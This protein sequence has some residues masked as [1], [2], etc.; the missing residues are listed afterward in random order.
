MV[1]HPSIDLIWIK[2]PLRS[3]AHRY[4]EAIDSTSAFIG[5]SLSTLNGS[6]RSGTRPECAGN[7]ASPLT[8]TSSRR[9]RSSGGA[10]NKVTRFS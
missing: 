1:D 9:T 4:G 3:S 5:D 7:P 2:K 8:W 6:G 10:P